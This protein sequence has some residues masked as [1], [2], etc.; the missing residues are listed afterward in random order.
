MATVCI[1]AGRVCC[2][3]EGEGPIRA[4]KDLFAAHLRIGLYEA[5]RRGVVVCCL[6]EPDAVSLRRKRGDRD[7]AIATCPRPFWTPTSVAARMAAKT[8][9][10][11][12]AGQGAWRERSHARKLAA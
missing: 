5:L 12:E 7:H 9:S 6:G 2:V 11:P 1:S 10:P 4:P 8:P 3:K